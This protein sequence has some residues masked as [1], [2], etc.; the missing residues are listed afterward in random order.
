M[1]VV[2]P[3]RV[4]MASAQLQLDLAHALVRYRCDRQCSSEPVMI[5]FVSGSALL[6]ASTQLANL[7]GISKCVSATGGSCSLAGTV[8]N[9]VANRSSIKWPVPVASLCAIAL[10]VAWKHGLHRVLPRRLHIV[11]FA[12]PLVMVL[13]AV[14]LMTYCGP[15]MQAAGIKLGEHIPPGLPVPTAPFPGDVSTGDVGALLVGAIAPTLLGYME[16]S[17]TTWA[18]HPA[19][20]ASCTR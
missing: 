2:E 17:D 11:R 14:L 10:L 16:V 19:P 13:A 5:G 6:T 3:G 15:T 7:F 8:S 18:A 1:S 20:R 12:A 9:L 4:A